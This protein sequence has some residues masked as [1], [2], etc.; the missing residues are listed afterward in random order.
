M[1]FLTTHSWG[2]KLLIKSQPEAADIFITTNGKPI[3]LGSTP[4]QADLNEIIASYIKTDSFL[5]E[6]KKPGHMPYRLLLAKTNDVD[7][8]LTANLE[9]DKAVSNL[10]EH[11]ALMNKLFN[12]QKLIRSRNFKDAIEELSVLEKSYPDFSIIPEL[13]ATA[14]YMN[15]DVENALSYYR[16][17]FALNP[18]NRDAYSMKVYL[19]KKLGL[20]SEVRQ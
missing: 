7:I 9:L 8:E 1:L 17:A 6:L 4:Y 2:A 10:K 15:K 11:D 13:K 12:V 3:R 14:Y 16:R 20:D 5:I 18:E 19:E